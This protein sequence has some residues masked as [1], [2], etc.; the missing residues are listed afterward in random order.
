MAKKTRRFFV[1]GLF[2]TMGF[3]IAAGTVIWISAS[4]FFQRGDLY[5]TFFDDSVQ[6]LQKDSEVKFQG[7][8]VGR[9]EK[10]SIAPDNKT[11]QVLMTIDPDKVPE[12]NNKKVWAQMGMAG[13]TGV[14]FVN[15]VPRGPD[16]PE[17][18]E[19]PFPIE[20]PFIAS[21]PSEITRIITGIQE[22]LDNIKK[23]DI[24]GTLDQVKGAFQGIQDF[25]KSEEIKSILAKADGAT[26]YL[27]NVLRGLDK[28]V[29]EGKVDDALV[30]ARNAFK[31]VG[32]LMD[33]VKAEL[34]QSKI[35]ETVKSARLTL[36]N[37]KVLMENL[38]RTS[39]TL[40]LLIERLYNRPPDVL[41]GKPPK[42]RWNEQPG[43]PKR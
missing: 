39:E 32:S 21:R 35:P 31:N 26:G 16:D 43:N 9:V 41:F 40:D 22:A 25:L 27:Q 8:T 7:V 42:A 23:A 28:T 14:M 20:H 19:P 3:L 33:G 2:V 29:A 36:D 4:R 37:A 11:V 5:V 15:L 10:I 18:K 12:F 13:I 1:V 30:E 38:R 6:G 24:E 34:R 17:P